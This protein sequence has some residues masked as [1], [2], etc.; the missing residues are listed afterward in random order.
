MRRHDT[1]LGAQHRQ[2]AGAPV[3]GR[4]K[5]LPHQAFDPGNPEPVAM[6]RT[7]VLRRLPAHEDTEGLWILGVELE[8]CRACVAVELSQL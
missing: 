3:R 4:F 2:G 6:A 5:Q 8:G 7:P 1:R